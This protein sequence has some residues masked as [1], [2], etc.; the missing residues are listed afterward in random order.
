MGVYIPRM[1]FYKLSKVRA[2]PTRSLL[3]VLQ[4]FDLIEIDFVRCGECTWWNEETHGCNRNP[5]V[6]PWMADDFCSFGER[7]TDER[8]NK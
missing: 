2:T 8:I 3:D 7:R 6:E 4:G 5:S 1:D